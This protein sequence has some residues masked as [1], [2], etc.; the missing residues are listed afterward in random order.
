MDGNTL[1]T[2]TTELLGGREL[3]DTLFFQLANLAKQKREAMRPWVILREE[4]TSLTLTAGSLY[5]STQALPAKFLQLH[6]SS[7]RENDSSPVVLVN[8][9]DDI[10]LRP[11][12]QRD[13]HQNRRSRRYYIDY[14]NRKIG[15]TGDYDKS[16]T[17][18]L[19]YIAESGDI[20]ANTAWEFD[21]YNPIFGPLIAADVAIMQKGEIDYDEI[22]AR[23]VQF[24]GL[25]VQTIVREM[26]KWDTALA[27]NE[28]EV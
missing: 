9:E 18:H 6:G 4:D 24:H 19:F 16:Y 21:D 12:S 13:I 11:I 23:M 25:N 22:N 27:M 1:K 28:L 5:T 15:F 10:V 14:K 20:D 7:R 26:I 8:G 2:L 3:G 17:V